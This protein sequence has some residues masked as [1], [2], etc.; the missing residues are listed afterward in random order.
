VRRLDGMAPSSQR[1]KWGTRPHGS[2][3][4]NTLKMVNEAERA[5]LSHTNYPVFFLHLDM[6][7]P[8]LNL[9]VR[10]EESLINS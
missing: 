2:S 8:E 6:V 5:Y 1:S 10:Y 7:G 9:W 4:S 3:F